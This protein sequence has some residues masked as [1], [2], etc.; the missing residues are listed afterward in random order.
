MYG[1]NGP[2]VVFVAVSPKVSA[3]V[4][5]YY[6]LL[7]WRQKKERIGRK[8]F[9]C[10]LDVS[11]L[12]FSRKCPLIGHKLVFMHVH[13]LL[14]GCFWQYFTATDENQFVRQQKQYFS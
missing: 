6:C 9:T 5:S 3:F 13:W 10:T 14:K 8:P 11:A 1:T 12:R 4:I 2:G 7:H